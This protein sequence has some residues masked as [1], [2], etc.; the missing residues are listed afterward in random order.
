MK[1]LITGT[2]GQVGSALLKTLDDDEL[3]P[4]TRKDCDL[5]SL[6][7]IKDIFDNNKL[8][9]IINAAAYTKVD[10]A[11]DETKQAF[12]INKNAPILMASKAKELN[13]PII[14]FSTDYI[15]DGRKEGGYCEDDSPN[16]L[17]VYG[18][19]KLEGENGIQEVGGQYYIFRTSWVYSNVGHNFYLTMKKLAY[20]KQALNIVADQIGSPTSNVFIAEQIKKIIPQLNKR[21]S[22]IY[23]LVPDSSCSWFEFAKAIISKTNPN[24]NL[25]QLYAIKSNEFP[26][27][28]A[29]PKNSILVNNKIKNKFKL[30]FESWQ[31]ELEKII[32][33]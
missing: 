17:G 1:I 27:K 23:H 33:E 13:I 25:E 7:Q 10:L 31:K 9:L 28:A 29:R 24:F 16:P 18:K 5:A 12:Q 15:F 20:E 4:I 8:D 22:G 32:Y 19:S 6:D 30:T 26:T 21:N 14:H 2:N 11:E 3:I